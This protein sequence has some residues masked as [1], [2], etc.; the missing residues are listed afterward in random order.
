MH[1]VKKKGL[2]PLIK[3]KKKTLVGRWRAN[4]LSE[5]ILIGPC[6]YVLLKNCTC[7]VHVFFYHTQL[8]VY[9]YNCKLHNYCFPD[10]YL[11]A[12]ICSGLALGVHYMYMH[13]DL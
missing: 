7:T 12:Q 4:N 3:K 9:A 11:P 6:D 2:H 8:Q 13:L 1:R 5:C 10:C